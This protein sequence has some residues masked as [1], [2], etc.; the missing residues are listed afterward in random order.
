MTDLTEK[1]SL[2]ETN[3]FKAF[4]ILLLLLLLLL[5][6]RSDLVHS[7]LRH[8]MKPKVAEQGTHLTQSCL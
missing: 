4:Q 6:E 7:E 8:M 2:E 1:T 3:R 5:S